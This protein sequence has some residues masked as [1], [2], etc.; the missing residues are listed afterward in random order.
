MAK[1]DDRAAGV[2][3]SE[4][5]TALIKNGRPVVSPGL[6]ISASSKRSETS[7]SSSS[8]TAANTVT[9]SPTGLARVKQSPKGTQPQSNNNNN[10]NNS[11]TTNNNGSNKNDRVSGEK[12]THAHSSDALN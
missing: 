10:N 3:P 1:E 2:A 4:V 7:S 9:L 12:R 5:T 8:S 6:V 11:S